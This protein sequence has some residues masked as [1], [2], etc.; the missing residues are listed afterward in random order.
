MRKQRKV[1]EH[2]PEVPPLGREAHDLFSVQQDLA[3]IG[4]NKPGEES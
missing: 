2:D 1:L 4:L 3:R